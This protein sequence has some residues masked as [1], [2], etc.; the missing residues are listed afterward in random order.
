[1]G[2]PQTF[3]LSE[4]PM[5]V[6]SISSLSTGNSQAAQSNEIS[7]ARK[8]KQDFD[9]L[10][11]ALTSNN[12]AG[13]Q[14]AFAT[15]QQDLKNIPQSQGVQQSQAA[16]QTSQT[17]QPNPRDA[18][19]ALNQALNSGNLTGAQNAFSA[20]LQ[21][22]QGQTGAAHHHRH[23]QRGGGEQPAAVA[24]ASTAATATTASAPPAATAI[25]TTA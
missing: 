4:V 25:N 10:A 22:L 14:Q 1:V 8:L 3:Q 12:L 11:Q 9:T 24:G 18:L 20:L 23:H 16:Q 13:A 6:N 21:D 7:P 19:A 17:G 5:S 2:S 15:F